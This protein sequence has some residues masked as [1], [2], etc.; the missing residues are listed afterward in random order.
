MG[1]QDGTVPRDLEIAP[2]LLDRVQRTHHGDLVQLLK[3]LA[4]LAHDLDGEPVPGS[5]PWLPLPGIQGVQCDR[6]AGQDLHV[7]AGAL[8]A[9]HPCR[10]NDA[11]VGV[12]HGHSPDLVENVESAVVIPHAVCALVLARS[13]SLPPDPAERRAVGREDR[14]LAGRLVECHHEA[15]IGEPMEVPGVRDHGFAVGAQDD[16][17]CDLDRAGCTEVFH[18]GG[19]LPGAGGTGSG[20]EA[21]GGE[22]GHCRESAGDTWFLHDSSVLAVLVHHPR[23]QHSPPTPWWW[24]EPFGNHS[25]V[26]R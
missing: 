8:Q 26:A 21:V 16:I 1:G 22:N 2:E 9:R 5:H 4:V 25:V 24:A 3:E 19:D 17:G 6:S 11:E 10:A 7:Q 15:A 13:L 14:E 20:E 23:H 12:Q 18:E